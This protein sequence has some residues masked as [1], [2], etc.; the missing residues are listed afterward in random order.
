MNNFSAKNIVVL[1]ILLLISLIGLFVVENNKVKV[2]QRW[3]T[4]KLRAAIL[5]AEAAANIKDYRLINS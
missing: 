1:S 3:Y 5:V 4:K 2:K